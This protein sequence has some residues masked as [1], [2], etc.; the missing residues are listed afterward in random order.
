[1][2]RLVADYV[3]RIRTVAVAATDNGLLAPELA[4]GIASGK[5]AESARRMAGGSMSQLR[6]HQEPWTVWHLSSRTPP[7][8]S[9]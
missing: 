7:L 2:V 6:R 4:A 5:S 1:V 3:R 9:T 8:V